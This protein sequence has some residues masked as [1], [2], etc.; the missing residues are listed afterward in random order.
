MASSKGWNGDKME[1]TG[2]GKMMGQEFKLTDVI[3]KSADGKSFAVAG[4]Y[5]AGAD[6]AIQWDMTCKK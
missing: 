5:A 2:T 1:W 6:K 3:T 4:F